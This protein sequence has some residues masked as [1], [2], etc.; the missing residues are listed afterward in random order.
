MKFVIRAGGIGPRLWPYSRQRKPK[1]FHAMAGEQTML[2]DAVGRIGSI[3]A[4][5]DVHVSTGAQMA[6]LVREQLPALSA[7]QLIVEP[8]LRNTG[9]A[10]GLECALLEARSL[11]VNGA[12]SIAEDA[13]KQL[14][15]GG[16]V[17]MA[18]ADKVAIVIENDTFLGLI[19]RMDLIN[20]LRKQLPS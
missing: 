14:E 13:I 20:Y 3:A 4:A 8:A 10:V 2:Q 5:D 12:V 1:Q 15:A 6:D 19:T 9:P 11:I 16:L 18:A 17:K 7:A